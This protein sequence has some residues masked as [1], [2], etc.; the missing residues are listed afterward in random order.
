MAPNVE[1][2]VEKPRVAYAGFFFSAF[3]GK[4]YLNR[5]RLVLNRLAQQTCSWNSRHQ[6]PS[7]RS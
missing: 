1:V 7:D 2:A 6:V 5:S 3:E 4:N